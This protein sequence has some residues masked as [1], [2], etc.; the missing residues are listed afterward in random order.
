[1]LLVWIYYSTQLVL[2]GA[3]FTRA[4]ANQFGS[5]VE[6]SDNAVAVPKT[7]LARL[8]A[9]TEIKQGEI[10]RSPVGN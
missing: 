7:P 4:Y 3:E 2:M 9:E 6:P 5:H 1:V 8:A 10:P